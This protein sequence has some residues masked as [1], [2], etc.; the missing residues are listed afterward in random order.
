MTRKPPDG[1]TV[2]HLSRRAYGRCT[3]YYREARK[4]KQR[5]AYVPPDR[6]RVANS[7]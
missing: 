3:L 2:A 5:Q 1:L 7:P 6:L 4:R